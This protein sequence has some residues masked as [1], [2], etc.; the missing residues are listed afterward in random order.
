M[1][2][3]S[4]MWRLLLLLRRARFLGSALATA[5]GTAD[6][7]LDWRFGIEDTLN[8]LDARANVALIQLPAESRH[9]RCS[10]LSSVVQN[11]ARRS[12]KSKRRK[13]ASRV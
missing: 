2:A 3:R 7:P 12:R 9:G 8:Q 5:T 1:G 13:S 4:P 10:A 6:R 11:G